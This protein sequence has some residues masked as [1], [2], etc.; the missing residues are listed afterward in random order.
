MKAEE[1]LFV[2]QY[3]ELFHYVLFKTIK[4][5]HL[6]LFLFLSCFASM[7]TFCMSL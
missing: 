7:Y 4:Q 2:K 1:M 5:S 3:I 6:H